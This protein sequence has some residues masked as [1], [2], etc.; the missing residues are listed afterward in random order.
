MRDRERKR[1]ELTLDWQVSRL[2]DGTGVR[3]GGESI[4]RLASIGSLKIGNWIS[5]ST[6]S[7]QVYTKKKTK[8]QVGLPGSRL[9]RQQFGTPDTT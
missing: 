8:K 4:A 7:G 9:R 1:V 2:V 5:G 6:S 3:G